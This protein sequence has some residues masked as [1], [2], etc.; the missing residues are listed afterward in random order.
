MRDTVAQEIEETENR[1]DAQFSEY[2]RPSAWRLFL[3]IFESEAEIR[4]AIRRIA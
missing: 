2:L 3:P 1:I 4:P